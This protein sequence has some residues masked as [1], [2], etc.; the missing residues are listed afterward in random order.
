MKTLEF[1]HYFKVSNG[2]FYFEDREMFDF[3]KRSLEGKRGYAIIKEIE[4][5]ISPNQFAYYFGG[6]IRGE[7]MNSNAFAGW[8]ERQIHE[9]LLKTLEGEVKP[10]L[11]KSGEVVHEETVP[12]FSMFRKRKM[13]EY[14]SKVIP[15]LQMEF[16]IHPKPSDHYKYNKFQLKTQIFSNEDME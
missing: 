4:E 12:D 9:Y 7:C 3:V 1:K 8:T 5:D 6:I 15:F 13:A 10:I 11:K 16:D 2:K 14:I